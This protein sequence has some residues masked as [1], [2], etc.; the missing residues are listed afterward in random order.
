VRLHRARQLLA[1]RLADTTGELADVWRFDGDRCARV[2]A[3]VM[4]KISKL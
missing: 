3:H 4:A 2:H 1:Q